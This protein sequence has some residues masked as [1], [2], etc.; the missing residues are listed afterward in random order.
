VFA[1]QYL[2]SSRMNT[3]AAMLTE[4]SVGGHL[5]SMTWPMLVG[6]TMIM[7][8]AFI[9]TWFL[10]LIG[11]YALAAYSFGFPIIMIV[12]SVAIGLGAGTSSVVARA[13]G[14]HD[15][16]RAKRLV[17]DSHILSLLISIVCVI[18]GVLTIDVLF[19]AL[20]A[21]PEMIPEIRVFMTIMYGAVPFIILGMVATSSMRAT[22]D[23]MLPSKLMIGASILN[24][25]LDPIFIFGFGPIPGMGLN[26]VAIA[27]LVSRAMFFFVSL[28]YLSHRLDLVTYAKPDG[29]AMRRSWGDVMHV[30]L[31]A[32]GTNVI[33]PMGL[34]LVTAMVA[35]YGPNAVAGFGVASR[36]EA[37][38]LVPYYALSAIIGPFV[39]QNLAAGKSGR[40]R[41]SLNLCAAFCIAS[42]LVIAAV[43]AMGS[44]L[45]PSLFSENPEVTDVTRIFLWVAPL[46]YGAYGI[47][48]VV[49]AAFNGL[50]KPMPGV[51][52]STLRVLAI[53]VPLAF[54]GKAL[55]G[56]IG[57]FAA[58]CLANL[59]SGV[60][61]YLWARST[62]HRLAVPKVHAD[63]A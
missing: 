35:S 13:I 6:I 52:I 58:Y 3:R 48:M 17:T 33:V 36:I 62:A 2:Y 59:V 61:G 30:G 8:Q 24:V 56:I 16:E 55:F 45:L 43:L 34:A 15:H 20:G 14:A 25:I 63:T 32:A 29:V 1:R 42:G 22:G 39:G 10:G 23:T 40:I 50:G 44:S 18:A 12:T 28:Y 41:R 31:P 54:L 53:Y 27:G 60:V 47:V 19:L 21:P 5:V 9:D 38:V 7:A 49:N 51:A 46:G 4:G 37:M 11:D 57:V 26:G